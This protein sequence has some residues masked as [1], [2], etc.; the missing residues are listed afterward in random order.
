MK[1]QFMYVFSGEAKEKLANAGFVLLKEDTLNDVYVFKADDKLMFSADW[2]N[3]ISV[4]LS[5]TLTF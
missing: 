1:G 3:D 4:V 5:D 2:M